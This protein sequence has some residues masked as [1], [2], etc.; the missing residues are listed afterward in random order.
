[1][2]EVCLRYLEHLLAFYHARLAT[3][4]GFDSRADGVPFIYLVL[5]ARQRRRLIY[6][7]KFHM[8][9][10]RMKKEREQGEDILFVIAQ[11]KLS[12]PRALDKYPS[13]QL[14][15]LQARCI[16]YQSSH[17]CWTLP[18]HCHWTPLASAFSKA[19][20]LAQKMEL[21]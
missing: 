20:M 12:N 8:F 11:L 14:I 15:A 9:K 21:S 4:L 5:D 3:C 16:R 7:V 18:P 13:L 19:A 17:A 10:K 6:A 2:T 1:M